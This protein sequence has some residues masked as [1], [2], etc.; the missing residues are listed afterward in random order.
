MFMALGNV[1]PWGKSCQASKRAFT[2]IECLV[3]ITIIGLLIGLLLPAIQAARESARRASCG[4]NLK[5]IGLALANYTALHG[6]L[7]TGRS[8][9][10]DPLYSGANPPCTSAFFDR[11]FLVAALPFLEQ[12]PLYNAM[13]HTR[14]CTGVENSTTFGIAVATFSC[15]SDVDASVRDMNPNAFADRQMVDPPSGRFRMAF[16]SYSGCFG[17]FAT[18]AYPEP[19]SGCVVSSARMAQ[20]NGSFNDNSRITLASFRDGLSH[21][22]VV[23]EKA[24]T[25]YRGL[26]TP[27]VIY[28]IRNGWYVS[29]TWGDT[30]FTTFYPPN[31][32]KKLHGSFPDDQLKDASSLHPG[33]LNA[34][35]GDGSVRF[36][37]ETINSWG[38]DSLNG[39]PAGIGRDPGGWWIHVPKPGVWQA[40]GSRNGA[41]V[42][43][44]DAL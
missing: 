13:N 28:A 6:C 32:Y 12:A 36:I 42:I 16:T 10:R 2:L 41:E 43:Q 24:T 3:V 14:L 4:N 11:S 7:P 9:T 18:D 39:E 23:S 22:I 27:S 35:M 31:L 34:L 37:K 26:D 29:G 21:T 20:N 40:L 30:L 19:Q 8:R 5:Q 25:S 44:N 15:P 33:G 17:S 1:H 38:L